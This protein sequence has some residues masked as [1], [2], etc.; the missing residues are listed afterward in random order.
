MTGVDKLGRPV[1]VS[2]A[3]RHDKNTRDLDESINFVL[4]NME[5]LI[6]HMCSVREHCKCEPTFDPSRP[7]PPVMC[8][9]NAGIIVILDRTDFSLSKNFDQ[10]MAS[11]VLPLIQ[12][13]YPEL[14][15]TLC[16]VEVGTAFNALY[17]IVS[18]FMEEKTKAKIRILTDDYK[19]PLRAM[20][21]ADQVWL[22]ASMQNKLSANALL[23]YHLFFFPTILISQLL[24]EHGGTLKEENLPLDYFG[25]LDS[26]S[27]F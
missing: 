5:R 17:Q 11:K 21:E 15:V 26:F 3:A 1:V 13:H 9:P 27:G 19:I 20:A 2:K 7:R 4:F 24:V 22:H 25:M 10:P 18:V 6:D 16:V 12:A 14:L 8:G 23:N